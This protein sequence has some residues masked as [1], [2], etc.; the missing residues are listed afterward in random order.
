[1]A[2][3]TLYSVQCELGHSE[4]AQESFVIVLRHKQNNLTSGG[5]L[6]GQLRGGGGE[7]GRGE[8]G[9]GGEGREGEVQA[10][11]IAAELS[12]LPLTMCI[13]QGSPAAKTAGCSRVSLSTV[14]RLSTRAAMAGAVSCLPS[15]GGRRSSVFRPCIITARNLKNKHYRGGG[16]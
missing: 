6:N 2:H 15:G 13:S 7:G 5:S 1:M 16:G 12:Q 10:V 9:R 11:F 4:H 14:S 8:E 3:S